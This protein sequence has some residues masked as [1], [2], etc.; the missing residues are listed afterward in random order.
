MGV[1]FRDFDICPLNTGPLNTGLTV[2]VNQAIG[3]SSVEPKT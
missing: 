3:L 1:D 2:H